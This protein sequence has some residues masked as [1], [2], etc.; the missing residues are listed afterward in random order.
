MGRG[1]MYIYDKINFT[2]ISFLIE[3]NSEGYI[4]K[5][6]ASAIR[7]GL[8][9][10]LIDMF[11]VNRCE[12]C[13][14]CFCRK[15]CIVQNIMYSSFEIKPDFVTEGES[16]GFRLCCMDENEYAEAGDATWFDMYFY[17]GTIAFLNP[18]IQALHVLGMSGLG[19]ENIT[20]SIKEIKNNKNIAL[21]NDMDIDMR[22]V[23]SCTLAEYITKRKKELLEETGKAVEASGKYKVKMSFN[24]PVTIKYHGKIINE[25]D[26]EAVLRAIA[27]R[28]YMYNL[29]EG[30][31]IGIID[32]MDCPE[33]TESKA[34]TKSVSRYSTRKNEKMKLYGI[35]GYMKMK[36]VTEET[37]NIL[38]AGEVLGCGKNMKFGFGNCRVKLL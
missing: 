36:D 31:D 38:I 10:K 22:A 16:A 19:R 21:L 17:G 13:D 32:V 37:L 28:I 14:E 23:A 27:R 1:T 34:Y 9:Q 30:N 2:K 15:K 24:T 18:V 7:G 33:I 12:N 4:P 8:G 25:F 29:Y 26:V 35:V 11:C 20:F 3:Y 6:K 5:N